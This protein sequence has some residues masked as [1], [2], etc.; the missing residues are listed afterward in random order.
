MLAP[1]SDGDDER[2]TLPLPTR[3]RRPTEIDAAPIQRHTF[4]MPRRTCLA[5]RLTRSTRSWRKRSRLS[6]SAS[7]KSGPPTSAG[8]GTS[9][10]RKYTHRY[11]HTR[12]LQSSLHPSSRCCTHRNRYFGKLHATFSLGHC[13]PSLVLPW[14]AVQCSVVSVPTVLHSP[15][16]QQRRKASAAWAFCDCVGVRRGKA[17]AH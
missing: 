14:G 9:R 4:D 6:S 5:G 12:F 2:A 1:Q 16:P 10:T 7:V 13:P 15:T 17:C 8:L 11:R 3:H